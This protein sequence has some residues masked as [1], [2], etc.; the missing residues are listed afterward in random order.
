MLVWSPRAFKGAMG[1]GVE[2]AGGDYEG[3]GDGIFEDTKA[4]MS[5]GSGKEGNHGE[6]D[7]VDHALHTCELPPGVFE[8]RGMRGVVV[9]SGPSRV[10]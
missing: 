7:Q 10:R 3:I 1:T 9:W 5:G 6:G 4:G 2:G 8:R